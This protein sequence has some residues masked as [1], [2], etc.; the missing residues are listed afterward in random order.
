MRNSSKQKIQSV[1]IVFESLPNLYSGKSIFYMIA[2][3]KAMTILENTG[4]VKFFIPEKG[5]GPK[6][7]TENLLLHFIEIVI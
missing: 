2:A 1:Y 7:K 4:K 3:K 6:R 5:N